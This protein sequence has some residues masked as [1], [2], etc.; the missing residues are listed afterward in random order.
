MTRNPLLMLIA[1]AAILESKINPPRPIFDQFP[2]FHP[3]EQV[4]QPPP[5]EPIKRSKRSSAAIKRRNI[6]RHQKGCRHGY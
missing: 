5:K 1:R 6:K 3:P 2:D 4:S